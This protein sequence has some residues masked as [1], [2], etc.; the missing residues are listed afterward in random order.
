MLTVAYN[1]AGTAAVVCGDD[2]KIVE[3]AGDRVL[4]DM[5]TPGQRVQHL[6]ISVSSKFVSVVN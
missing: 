4:R 1:K 6:V 5:P 2:L 3:I